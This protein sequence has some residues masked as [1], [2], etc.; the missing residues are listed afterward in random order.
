MSHRHS[1]VCISKFLVDV[2]TML[3]FKLNKHVMLH[4][5][6]TCHL[7]ICTL[8]YEWCIVIFLT[9]SCVYIFAKVPN[10]TIH[11]QCRRLQRHK[12]H[13]KMQ[14]DI[15]HAILIE[16]SICG[17]QELWKIWPVL[18]TNDVL[19]QNSDAKMKVS[20]CMQIKLLVAQFH[21]II[22]LIHACMNSKNVSTQCRVPVWPLLDPQDTCSH[23]AQGARS[24]YSRNMVKET[25]CSM[26]FL[27][28]DK[29]FMT[30]TNVFAV[31]QWASALT[32][33]QLLHCHLPPQK[34]M[35]ILYT[36]WWCAYHM[37]WVNKSKHA[38]AGL[39]PSQIVF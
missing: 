15:L 37:L 21:N 36:S 10:K 7:S 14:H 24:I 22:M 27:L 13:A 5:S 12:W 28:P 18:F 32:L 8:V 17:C 29:W 3:G 35:V 4:S 25:S 2:L 39:L 1:K 38:H 6:I 16:H 23:I 9:F 19:F 30:N 31:L 11:C 33:P 26:W 20:T 34:N